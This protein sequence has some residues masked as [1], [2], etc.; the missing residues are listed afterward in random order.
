MMCARASA[1]AEGERRDNIG[2]QGRNL[3]VVIALVLVVGLTIAYPVGAQI[4]KPNFPHEQVMPHNQLS[5][6]RD[7]QCTIWLSADAAGTQVVDAQSMTF[8]GGPENL[9][10]H[11]TV[12]NKSPFTAENFRVDVEERILQQYTGGHTSS[13]TYSGFLTI[14]PH[15]SRN[16]DPPP[17]QVGIN[18][19]VSQG[20]GPYEEQVIIRATV[21]S[22]QKVPE[23]DESNNSCTYQVWVVQYHGW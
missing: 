20:D 13:S 23:S 15:A 10:F 12:Q 8:H 1:V 17:V 21:D 16:Y 3:V 18:L 2:S 19:P 5:V 7:L 22:T 4:P 6:F 11:V 9:F 14:P